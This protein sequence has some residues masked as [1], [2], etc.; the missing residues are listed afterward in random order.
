MLGYFGY[1]ESE[2]VVLSNKEAYVDVTNKAFVVKFDLDSKEEDEDGMDL[3]GL[4]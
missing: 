2:E 4:F 1:V 3:G